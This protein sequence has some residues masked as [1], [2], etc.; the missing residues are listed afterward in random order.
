[1]E[2]V[3]QV[4]SHCLFIGAFKIGGSISA[5]I[6]YYHGACPIATGNNAFEIAVI[7]RMIFDHHRKTLNRW[8]RRWS[9]GYRPTFQ[10]PFHFQPE[11]IVEV[12][13]IMF[14]H[15]EAKLAVI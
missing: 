15:Y 5:F 12:R 10:D 2:L 8:I 7:V 1:M 9:L 6:P 13:G 14:L 3:K 11:I 4:F